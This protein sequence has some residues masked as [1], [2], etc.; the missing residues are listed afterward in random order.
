MGQTV[1][2]PARTTSDA[3]SDRD[4]L[5]S[6]A[7]RFSLR[8]LIVQDRQTQWSTAVMGRFREMVNLPRGWDGYAGKPVDFE[9]ACFASQLLQ[10]LYL[11]PVPTPSLVPGSDG[12]LQIEWHL[13]GFDI[14]L[15]V[16]GVNVVRAWRRDAQTGEEV[17]V[18]L[19]NDFAQVAGWVSEMR[20]RIA[21]NAVAAAA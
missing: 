13:A 3:G 21:P 19:S 7:S 11:D 16:L 8:R 12:S 9:I 6:G 20:D 18:E 1:M 10:A 17:E 15:D 14:E 2:I 5:R 4:Q